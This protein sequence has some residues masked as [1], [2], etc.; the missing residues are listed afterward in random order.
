MKTSFIRLLTLLFSFYVCV[1]IYAQTPTVGKNAVT[2]QIP[3]NAMTVISGD[4]TAVQTSISYSDGFSRS[5]QVIQ[6]R[7]VPDA[8]KDLVISSSE[9]DILGRPFKVILPTPAT[10]ATGGFLT[11]PQANAVSFYGDDAPFSNVDTYEASPLN[12]ALKSYGAGKAWRD[13]SKYTEMQYEK[14]GTEIYL[15]TLNGTTITKSNYPANSLYKEIGISERGNRSI[16]YKDKLGR[17]VQKSVQDGLDGS[18]NP[19]YINISYLFDQFDR[20]SVVISPELYKWFTTHSTLT[21]T[22]DEFKE[23][24]YFYEYDRRGRLISKQVPGGGK[25]S[26]VYDKFD[27]VVLENDLKDANTTPVNYY[28]FK[29]YDALGRIIMTGLINNIGG[30][31]RASL[32]ND[33][34]IY[35]GTPYETRTASGGLLGYTN[36]SFPSSYT[37]AEINVKSVMYYDNYDWNTD[38]LFNFQPANAFHAQEDAKGL[39]TGTLFRN[40]ETNVWYKS[41]N[42]YDFKKRVIE[43][44]SENHLGS[45][46]RMDYQYRFNGE[47]LKMRMVHQG[48]T[49]IYDY[50]YN[51]VGNKIRFTHTKD[52]VTQNI[53]QYEMDGIGRLKNKTFKP[54]GSALVSKQTGNWADVNTWLSGFLPSV[55]DNVTI[56]TGHTITIP[57]GESGSAGLLNDKGL[58]NNFGTL[59]MGKISTGDLQIVDY[60]YHIIGGLKGINLDASGNLTNK[61]FSL[62]LSYEEGAGG[63]FDGNISKQE[64]KSNIDNITRSFTYSYDES[65]R[66]TGGLYAG[67]GTENYSLNSVS[68][69]KN[70]NIKTLS[71]SGYKSDNTFGV[72]DNLAYTYQANSNKIQAVTDNSGETASFADATGST[73]Y[74][75][76]EDGSLKSDANKGISLIEY[77]Y[78]KLPKRIVKGTTTILYQYDASG[79]KLKE[80]IGANVTDYISNLIYKNGVLYQLRHDEGRIVN[81]EHE[82]HIQDHLGNL[83]IAFRDSLGIAKI[84]QSEAYGIWGENLPSLSYLKSSW[85]KDD[86]R[87]NGKEISPETGFYDYVKRFYDPLLGR[88]ITIDSRADEYPYW[89][90]YQFA[91]NMPTKYVDLDGMEPAYYDPQTKRVIPASDYLRHSIPINATLVNTPSKDAG[92]MEAGMLKIVGSFI[93]VL[94][95]AIDGHDAVSD[96]NEGNYGMAA[97]S[98][99][100]LIPAADFVTKPLKVILKNADETKDLV[101]SIGHLEDAGKELLTVTKSGSRVD[102]LKI[103][104]TYVGELGDDAIAV[105]GRLNNQK[106]RV[107]GLQSANKQTGWRIDWDTKKGTHYNYWNNETGVRG[108]VLFNG[109]KEQVERLIDMLTKTYK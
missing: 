12:R 84:S 76:W 26:Y 55:N 109:N 10:G 70:G 65:S 77:N 28:I 72:V 61:I 71:R 37:P 30:F 73:D 29:K 96:F 40:L 101:K 99:L 53:V 107:V 6:Y 88:F 81:G 63:Y 5:T 11:T 52:G 42:Y 36:T 95:W 103:A 9:F 57:N 25:S 98:G 93:P 59:S 60:S 75:Y 18:S 49:E 66:I 83:R 80:T 94:D 3:R 78:L 104:K 43:Q 16:T 31:S 69:D 35:T 34:D 21:T 20:L 4:H 8:S 91:G 100:S 54:V 106:G 62:K 86:F 15:F 92:K 85:K 27:R 74:T 24:A 50:F 13:N 51:H 14:V 47:V 44:F 7:G 38:A 90:Q 45:I 79:K 68:Y 67:N 2:E 102:A 39:M 19:T 97:L 41:I 23:G 64:W 46:D 1:N 58:L 32:Q 108:A 17:V 105:T 87:F 48:I 22:Q 56:N 33:F 82:Y 89:T